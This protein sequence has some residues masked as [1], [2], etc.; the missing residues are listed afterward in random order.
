MGDCSQVLQGI[1]D[2][3]KDEVSRKTNPKDLRPIDLHID[4]SDQYVTMFEKMAHL[5]NTQDIE[6]EFDLSSNFKNYSL[7]DLLNAF[8]TNVRFFA[9]GDEADI[10]YA[11]LS[12]YKLN[13]AKNAR[14]RRSTVQL[15]SGISLDGLISDLSSNNIENQYVTGFGTKFNSASNLL[16][17][18]SEA[19][20]SVAVVNS[21]TH[22]FR[23]NQSICTL[24]D[25]K[26]KFSL[27]K[28][29]ERS[30][31]V[32]FVDPHFDHSFFKGEDD[33]IIV[34]YSDQYSNA[35]GFDAIT[36]TRKSGQYE[37]LLKEL[38]KRND[39]IAKDQE[40]PKLIDLYNAINGEWLLKLIGKK[41]TTIQMEKLSI[42]SAIKGFLAMYAH[43]EVVWVP[44]SLEE[45]LR[46]S[47]GA[48]LDKSSGLFSAKNLGAAKEHS[49]DLL[50][51]GLFE[52]DG[53]L[54]LQF[55]PVEVKI[56]DMNPTR[57]NHAHNQVKKTYKLLYDHLNGAEADFRQVFY[58]NF[59]A[60]LILVSA[61]KMDF[62]NIWDEQDWSR[63]HS[64]Y[65]EQLMSNDFEVTDMLDPYL[66]KY[67]IF[68][69]AN[70]EHIRDISKKDDLMLFNLLL[71]DGY[72]WLIKDIEKHR[73]WVF[74]G[75]HTIDTAL[76]FSTKLKAISD[77]A[78]PEVIDVSSDVTTEK[79]KNDEIDTITEEVALDS[80]NARTEFK[81]GKQGDIAIKFGEEVNN[82]EKIVWKPGDTTKVMHTNT[83]IIGTM[84]TGKT[85]F[86]K[87][88]VTQLSRA[89]LDNIGGK[90]IGI[91]IFDYKGDYLDKEFTEATGAKIYQLHNLP[92]NP[93]A[94]DVSEHSMP[95]L[96]LHIASTLQETIS[97]AFNLGNKQKALLK[98]A[99]MAAYQEKGIFKNQPETWTRTAPTISDVCELYLNDEKVAVDSL[100]AAL[101]QLHD[102]EIFQPDGAKTRS[103]YDLIDGVT[104]IKLS[105]YSADIQNLVV[106]ITLDAFYS[107][108]Q[109]NGHSRIDGNYRQLTKMVLVDEADNFLSKNFL[110][111][112]KILKEGR[113][114]GVG[115]ILSTQFLNHF[116]TAENEYDQYI[117]TWIIHRVNDVKVKDI[118]AL[119][120]IQEKDKK[121]KLIQ[122]IKKLQKHQSLVSLGGSM[123]VVIEDL[124]FWKLME[125]EKE[126][127]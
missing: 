104:V 105:G 101:S 42:A 67:G 51:V 97:N 81:I 64:M 103:L 48:G 8:R 65:R 77:L 96:P 28:L 118:D 82:R 49:D 62:Y 106:A 22:P 47:S 45:I 87:S 38:L 26:L 111:L 5:Y 127:K 100:H 55:Y 80:K 44:L 119:F 112:R 93:L 114:F 121:E 34:H 15:V 84:G 78:E 63:V 126:G 24:L 35:S 123:P 91:L 99:I 73:Q 54:N 89:S 125:S 13:N 9:Y 17:K 12:F 21:T 29:Y 72:S 2:Y 25:E 46:V 4:G 60:K 61:G 120:S 41:N 71:S 75:K 107:Q 92:Y 23:H 7:E 69:F 94:I 6:E 39:V 11:H 90:A 79:K 98:E 10:K 31:W 27:D 113:E 20:N 109:K 36:V 32:T 86:T 117:L 57:I 110:S 124:P 85:Q 1:F 59:F 43:P 116:S 50:M 18:M 102:F 58:R 52:R 95:L 66:G 88:V 37:Y 108:M 16:T 68:A 83:G 122:T 19:C 56:G 3:Y 76:L 14:S 115:T 33:I 70:D 74:E 40:I 53:K 30:Q